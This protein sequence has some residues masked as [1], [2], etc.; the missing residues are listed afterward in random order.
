[1]PVVA[2]GF[3]LKDEQPAE[4]QHSYTCRSYVSRSSNGFDVALYVEWKLGGEGFSRPVNFNGVTMP[5]LE[6]CISYF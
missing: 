4:F 5:E 6:D 1:M 2:S 3:E